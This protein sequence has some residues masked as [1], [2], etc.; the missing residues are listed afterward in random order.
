MQVAAGAMGVAMATAAAGAGGGGGGEA[1]SSAIMGDLA[2][3]REDTGK[4]K[5]KMTTVSLTLVSFAV[6]RQAY[7]RVCFL[8][9]LSLLAFLITFLKACACM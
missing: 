7:Q 4:R 3:H 6:T 8:C 1:S 9:S 5:R 2:K